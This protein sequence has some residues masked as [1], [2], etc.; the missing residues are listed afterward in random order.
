MTIVSRRPP[1]AAILLPLLTLFLGALMV[2]ATGMGYVSIA[3]DQVLEAL[4]NGLRGTVEHIDPLYQSI[5]LDVRLPRIITA[6]SVGFGLAVA[7][8]VF[9]GLLLNPLADPFTLGVSS[10]SAFGA[11][12]ALLLGFTFFGPTTLC[13]T[14]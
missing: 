6:L 11:A 1:R 13:F 3:P 12:L 9:Q 10:G 2:V 7:G 14:A 4:W 5:I 8:A